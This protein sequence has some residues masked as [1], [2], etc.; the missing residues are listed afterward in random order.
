M[1]APPDPG[2]RLGERIP[3][4]DV[5]L[6]WRAEET[7][8]RAP[9]KAKGRKKHREPEVGRLLNISVS[10]GAVVAPTASDLARGSVLLVQLGNAQAAVRIR[11]IEDFGDPDWR[12]YGVEFVETEPS[13]LDWINHLLDGRRPESVRDAWDH[14]L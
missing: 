7:T 13:F 8:S 14:A 6:T 11:R 5:F 4:G 9:A 12:T 1:V 10:G 3:I 2:R